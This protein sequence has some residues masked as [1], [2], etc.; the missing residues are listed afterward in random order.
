MK[1]S[2]WMTASAVACSKGDSQ[3]RA[4]Q[5]MWEHDCGSVPVVGEGGRVEGVITDR[6]IAMSAYTR[7]QGLGAA[8]V[9][10]AMSCYVCVCG[11]D[12]GIDEALESMANHQL[13]RLPVVDSE[14]HL[15]GILS[16]A[17]VV[18]GLLHEDRRG[19]WAERVL[20]VLGEVTR[21][22]VVRAG[23]RPETPAPRRMVEVVA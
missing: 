4:A 9:E 1:V 12:D 3:E 17:D 19:E 18:Q 11:P 2:E 13:H 20:E 5:I 7:G 10:S 8:P 23:D 16:L 15:V 21:P 22:R 14:R 6:D